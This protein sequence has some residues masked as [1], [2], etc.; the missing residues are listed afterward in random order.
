MCRM[1]SNTSYAPTR[2]GV[3]LVSYAGNGH[4]T[5][6]ILAQADVVKFVTVAIP[7]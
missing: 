5:N 4:A 3:I 7:E 2:D 6:F 1:R